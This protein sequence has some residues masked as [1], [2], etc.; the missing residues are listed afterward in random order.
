VKLQPAFGRLISLPDG[1]AQGPVAVVCLG[2]VSTP[3]TRAAIET[4]QG[5]SADLER[6]GVRL[7]VLT[8]S[9]LDRVQGFVSR[10][11]VLFPM[12]SDPDGSIRAHFGLGPVVTSDTLVGLAREL[13]RPGR[14]LQ[15]GRGWLEPGAY[16]P[17]AC[18]VLGADTKVAWSAEGVAFSAAVDAARL[19]PRA[20]QT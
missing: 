19:S 17:A 15:T 16:A 18:F 5:V 11:H 12:V 2:G 13:R 10:Y 20:A 8:T 7:I 3:D 6:D 14:S 4:L 1:L 9:A